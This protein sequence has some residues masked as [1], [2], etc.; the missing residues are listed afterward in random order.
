MAYLKWSS[1]AR[2]EE[3]GIQELL[4]I[5]VRFNEESKKDE[6]LMNEARQWF[7]KMEKNDEM[8]LKIWKWFKEI[9]MKEFQRVYK[10]LKMSFDS[11]T[12]ESFYRDKVPALVDELEKKKLIKDS[13]G[14]KV[15][16]LSQY[17]K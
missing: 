5:Y 9:S 16:D 17:D 8:A 3:R 2:V 10:M 11:Y 4:D 15:I 6:N 7:V 12:G 14:A 13:Q 1:K